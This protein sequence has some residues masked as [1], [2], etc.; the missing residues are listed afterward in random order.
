MVNVETGKIQF[1]ASSFEEGINTQA[2][3]EVLSR[4]IANPIKKKLFKAK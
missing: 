4:R 1:V 3:A 2:A